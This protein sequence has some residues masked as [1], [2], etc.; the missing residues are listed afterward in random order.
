VNIIYKMVK[1]VTIRKTG[2]GYDISKGGVP[3]IF[4]RTKPEAKRKAEELR[5][6][7]RK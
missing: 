2:G 3:V 7:L 6:R 4:A 1:K 5:K